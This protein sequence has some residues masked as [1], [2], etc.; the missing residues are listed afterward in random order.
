MSSRRFGPESCRRLATWIALIAACVVAASVTPAGEADRRVRA[1]LD[2]VW[3]HG[4]TPEIAGEVLDRADL[5]R[6]LERLRDPLEPRRDNVV[7]F[8][9]WLA[10]D[11]TTPELLA[12]L[13]D[14]PVA[15]ERPEDDR[16]RLLVPLAL[17]EIAARGGA[18]AYEALIEMSQDG[19]R[20]SLVGIGEAGADD[21]AEQARFALV[22]AGS[23]SADERTRVPAHGPDPWVFDVSIAADGPGEALATRQDDPSPTAHAATLTFANHVDVP[24]PMTEGVLDGALRTATVLTARTDFEE[25]VACCHA[26][27]R[28]GAARAFGTPNDGLA[29]VDT[30]SEINSVLSNSIARTK[31]VRAINFCAEPGMNIIGCS[32]VR[33]PSM[34][35]VRLS[36]GGEGVLWLHEYGHNVGL[37]HNVD[38]RYIM[39]ASYNGSNRAI[40]GAECSTFHA[41]APG[42]AAILTQL[43]AC[44]DDDGDG[45]ASGGDNCPDVAN[46]TQADTDL[47]GLGDPCDNCPT[48]SN[49]SQSDGDG[50]GA[51]DAC[52]TCTDLDG[53]GFGAPLGSTCLFG[54]Q[55]DCDDSAAAINPGVPD[56]CDGIDNDCSGAADD[57]ICADFD[58]NGDGVLDGFE[59]TWVGRAFGACGAQ[60][61][62][63]WWA[64]VDFDRDGCVD[65]NDLALLATVWAC[66]GPT[67]VC[68]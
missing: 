61:S 28:G 10:D 25:D 40:D 6:L 52:D 56:I 46:P 60:P 53:D 9:A 26:V 30:D 17:G 22:R 39:Y 68:D 57:S 62:A 29:I 27:R 54:P 48:F 55:L 35:V 21:L 20:G 63:E 37:G 34:A 19:G 18:T 41:P 11:A 58:A 31:V 23:A 4:V 3:I 49:S 14:F 42:A 45:V 32:Y 16:A 66:A 43:G 5:P 36:G 67:A 44:H 38:S 59:L 12:W 7:A 15:S 24:N 1:A 33:G 2:T 47:D 65:G 64:A 51:G 50:D 8:L 13:A